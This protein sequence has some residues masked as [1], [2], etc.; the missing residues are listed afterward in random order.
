MET[1]ITG[2][3]ARLK[4]ARKAKGFTKKQLAELAGVSYDTIRK[5][6]D[7]TIKNP[8]EIAKIAEPL[9]VSPAWL[10]FGIDQLDEL[11]SDSIELAL[12]YKAL[13]AEQKAAFKSAIAE[14][15]KKSKT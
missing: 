3:A 2:L 1:D 10:Q 11:D 7:K 14:L 8:R 12:L 9:D 4:S 5:I 13:P 15:S 6:E